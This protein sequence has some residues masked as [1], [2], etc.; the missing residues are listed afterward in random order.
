MLKSKRARAAKP[1]VRKA[2]VKKAKPA[3]EITPHDVRTLEVDAAAQSRSERAWLSMTSGQQT[4][5]DLHWSGVE[6]HLL[7]KSEHAQDSDRRWKYFGK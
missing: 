7:A 5:E 4:T 6:E 1:A 3:P 2:A